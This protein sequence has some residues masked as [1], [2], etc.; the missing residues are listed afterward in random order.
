MTADEHAE[1]LS[2][3]GGDLREFA[4][5]FADSRLAL[6]K[7]FQAGLP[8]DAKVLTSSPALIHSDLKNVRP[9]ESRLPDGNFKE[10]Q[11]SVREV[12]EDLF[13]RALEVP[14]LARFALT[15]ARAGIDNFV[16][17]RKAAC[18]TEADFTESRAFLAVDTRDPIRNAILNPVWEFLLASNSKF[19]VFSVP[20]DLSTGHSPRDPGRFWRWRVQG[21]EY[22]GYRLIRALWK[23]LP[24]SLSRYRALILQDNEL[25]WETAFHLGKSGVALRFLPRLAEA[26]SVTPVT[27]AEDIALDTPNI[28]DRELIPVI[29]E[30]IR[31]W[32]VPQGLEPCKN[33][34]RHQVADRIRRHDQASKEWPAILDK[35]GEPGR[36]IV[37]VNTGATPEQ[38][39]LAE[40]C[41][42]RSIPVVAFQHGVTREINGQHHHAMA[43]YEN[44]VSD[45]FFTYNN[46]AS[47]ISKRSPFARGVCAAVGLPRQY[48]RTGQ[49]RARGN[50]NHDLLFVSTNLYKGNLNMLGDCYASDVEISCQEAKLIDTVLACLPHR[51]LYKPYPEQL[52][53]SDPDP[54]L[55]CARRATNIEIHENSV[56]TRY[57]FADHR[58]LISAVATSTTGWCLMSGKPY[59]FIDQPDRAPLRDEARMGFEEG[60][61]LFDRT[62]STFHHDLRNFLSQPLDAIEAAWTEK[63][64]KR[65]ALIDEFFGLPESNAGRNAAAYL[66]SHIIGRASNSGVGIEPVRS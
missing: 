26:R 6:E 10:L 55:E 36:S 54:I 40:V 2:H 56:D 53:Y 7:A 43:Y 17:L 57:L 59:V 64:N 39:A 42:D 41:R 29:E 60:V 45:L 5:V 20:I 22:I 3:K 16:A 65:R 13:E 9:I 66:K 52:R 58:V 31:R 37:L 34:F 61:F 46:V 15:I 62:S 47:E 25:L 11:R 33:L 21:P 63:A 38:V 12:S 35:L 1:I 19:H 4:T 14:D 27:P 50:S 48:L 49:R 28:V 30:R 8:K 23:A 44:C 51:V 32:V 18:L 24:L